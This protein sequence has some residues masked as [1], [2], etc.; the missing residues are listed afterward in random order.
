MG[1]CQG[2][3]AGIFEELGQW[4]LMGGLR[5]GKGRVQPRE[6]GWPSTA[7]ILPRGGGGWFSPAGGL[8]HGP[9]GRPIRTSEGEQCSAPN[10]NKPKNIQKE[11]TKTILRDAADRLALGVM[12]PRVRITG[13][14]AGGERGREVKGGWGRGRH[15]SPDCQ[16]WRKRTQDQAD[17][18]QMNVAD[19][20]PE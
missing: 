9:Q 13:G 10:K 20:T 16:T 15:Q 7:V 5:A 11:N 1:Q 18:E 3:S 6:A 8:G 12:H 19:E 2:S 17:S 14:K 4:Q